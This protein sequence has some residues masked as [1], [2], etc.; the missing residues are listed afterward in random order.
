MFRNLK[1]R[2]AMAVVALGVASAASAAWADSALETGFSARSLGMGASLR[3]A[4]TGSAAPLNPAGVA[5]VK[6][7]ALEGSYGYRPDDGET[8][9]TASVADSTSRVAMALYYS[10]TTASK[11]T[12]LSDAMGVRTGTVDRTRHEVG[13]STAFPVS[14]K[15]ALGVTPKYA[16]YVTTLSD[17]TTTQKTTLADQGRF[18]LD[19][20]GVIAIAPRLTLGLVGYNLLAHDAEYPRAVGGGLALGLG[21][22]ALVTLDTVVD[23]T[24]TADSHATG[25]DRRVKVSGGAEVVLANLYP[26]RA[27]AIWSSYN[28]D[29]YVTGGLGYQSDRVGLDFAIRQKVEGGSETVGIVAL[30]FFLPTDQTQQPSY[31]E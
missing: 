12:P 19:I 20:G 31:I 17:P 25:D 2:A 23:F 7:Y 21:A 28:S 11:D 16:S 9:V 18:N 10:Y 4:A 29:V 1:T 14:D 26:I 5:L 22:A 6:A 30:K 15:F 3:G 8:Q 27:G 24:S 13:A